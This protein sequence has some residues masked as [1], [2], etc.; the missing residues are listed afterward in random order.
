MSYLTK[1]RVQWSS[2]II[3]NKSVST[4]IDTKTKTRCIHRNSNSF[5]QYEKKEVKCLLCNNAH[6]LSHCDKFMK[7]E[8]NEK[9]IST[10]QKNLCINCLSQNH[11][12]ADCKSGNCKK[13][14]KK[15]HTMLH[16]EKAKTVETTE[17]SATI[18]LL[19]TSHDVL[20]STVKLIIY[21]NNNQ[22][23]HCHALL[24]SGS[25]SCFITEDLT[26]RIKV[27]KSYVYIP[28]TGIHPKIYC[29]KKQNYSKNSV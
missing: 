14:N 8:P 2:T 23:Q 7:M 25:Q 13:C 29:N 28:V 19:A 6:Y 17:T 1:H 5:V 22:P 3:K 16:F 15:H 11:K 9:L 27:K 21:D 26:Q 4:N 20:L 12:A 10:K 18:N 24:N